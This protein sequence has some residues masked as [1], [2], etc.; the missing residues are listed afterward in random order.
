MQE[1]SEHEINKKTHKRSCPLEEAKVQSK[2]NE[3]K[4]KNN[5]RKKERNL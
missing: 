4:L 1:N 3:R 5:K 2:E